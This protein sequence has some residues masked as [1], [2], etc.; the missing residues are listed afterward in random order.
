M[1]Y[2]IAVVCFLIIAG[3]VRFWVSWLDSRQGPPKP[4]GSSND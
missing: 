3:G 1:I 2:L 4:R